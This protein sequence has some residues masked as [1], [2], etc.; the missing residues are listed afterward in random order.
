M[1]KADS[2]L[3][4]DN[5]INKDTR[6]LNLFIDPHLFENRLIKNKKKLL[7]DAY[8]VDIDERYD[9]RP[10]RL[11]YEVYGEDF[12]YPALLIANNLGSL[13]QFKAD[14]LNYKCYI[15]SKSSIQQLIGGEVYQNV[16]AEDIVNEIFKEVK[17]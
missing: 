3:V 2:L 16:F 14:I 12:F 1:A 5:K 6:P 9:Y 10:D 13:L 7:K 15:P 17:I 11:A 8:L 4:N